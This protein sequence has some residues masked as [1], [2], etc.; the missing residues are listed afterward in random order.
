M[1][2]LFLKIFG[3]FFWEFDFQN[4]QK[5]SN[6]SYFRNFFVIWFLLISSTGVFGRELSCNFG[7]FD[8]WT[9]AMWPSFDYCYLNSVDLS[10]SFKAQNHSFSGTPG[11]KS[12]VTALNIFKSSKIDFLPK[13]IFKEFPNLNG[14]I[15]ENSRNFTVIKNDLFT[16]DFVVIQYLNLHHNKI[17]AIEDKAFQHLTKL[18]WIRLF[19]NQIKSLPFQIFKDNPELIYVDLR[20]NKINSITPDF[21]KN[22]EKLKFVEYGRTNPCIDKNFGCSEE[23]CLVSQTDLDRDLSTCF[24]NCLKDLDCALKSEKFD[25]FPKDYVEKN[26]DSIVSNGHLNLLIEKGYTDLLIER[27]YLKLIV[28][29]GFLD[30]LVA[31]NH[32]DLLIQNGYLGMLVEKNYTDLLIEKGYRDLIIENDWRLKLA[33]EDVQKVKDEAEITQLNSE[34]KRQAMDAE[35]KTLKQELIELRKEFKSRENAM[36]S[37]IK[38]LKQ[39]LLSRD[40]IPGGNSQQ[41]GQTFIEW[42]RP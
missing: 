15:F 1:D 3:I 10:E 20:V 39:Q 25:D 6:C 18:K 32:L 19:N 24:S 29:S 23:T 33:Y 40:R 2:R 13:E 11:E 27:G 5:F 41:I 21:F 8:G 38:A 34:L 17:Q 37:E 42:V 35:L 14:L 31:K 36:Q 4:P 12:T 26:L 7:E 30:S 9:D 22:L 28:D 16:E